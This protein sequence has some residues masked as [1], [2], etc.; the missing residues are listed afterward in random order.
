MMEVIHNIGWAIVFSVVGGLVGMLLVLFASVIVPRLI[1]RFT[2]NIDE[3][4]ELIR[5]NSAVAEYYGRL[6]SSAIIGVSIVV[7]AAVLGGVIA[8]LH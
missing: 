3:Q 8:A 5:G 7:A 4:K 2:P 1:D 6:V